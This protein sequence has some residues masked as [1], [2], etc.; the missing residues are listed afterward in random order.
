MQLRVLDQSLGQEIVAR[1]FLAS[2]CHK[3]SALVSGKDF[4][5]RGAACHFDPPQGGNAISDKWVF[6]SPSDF[7]NDQCVLLP[8]S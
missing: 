5:T 1:S 6:L 8:D 4:F 2:S 3:A 7:F